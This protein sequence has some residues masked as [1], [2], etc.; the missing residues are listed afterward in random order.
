MFFWTLGLHSLS[1]QNLECVGITTIIPINEPAQLYAIDFVNG[2]GFLES[3]GNYETTDFI[4]EFKDAGGNVVPNFFP[5]LPYNRVYTYTVTHVPT[6]QMCDDILKVI[7]TLGIEPIICEADKHFA[8]SPGQSLEMLPTDFIELNAQKDKWYDLEIK[9]ANGNI[10]PANTLTY[11]AATRT[12]QATVTEISGNSC[13]ANFMVSGKKAGNS[14]A[15]CKSNLILALVNGTSKLYPFTVD[16]GSTDYVSLKLNRSEF[17]CDDVDRPIKVKLSAYDSQN[18]ISQCICSVRVEDKLPPVVQMYSNVSV[19]IN[20]FEP[21]IITPELV[22]NYYDNCGFEYVQVIPNQ[23]TCNSPNPLNVKLIVKDKSGATVSASTNVSFT[24]P[25]INT[26]LICKEEITIEVNPYAPTK[27]TPGL[28]LQGN[29]NCNADLQIVLSYNGSNF[30]KAEL[31]WE[32]ADKT[33]LGVI[34]DLTTGNTCQ[35]IILVSKVDV[36]TE[37]FTVCDT[38]CPDG[39]PGDCASGYSNDD[40]VD[41]PCSFDIFICSGDLA[42]K[43]TPE[44]LETLHGVPSKNV[45]PQIINFNCPTIYMVYTDIVIGLAPPPSQSKKVVRTWKVY[46]WLDGRIYDYI[47]VFKI[48]AEGLEICDTLPWNTPFGD[49]ASGHTDTDAVE[50]PA[51]ITVSNASVSL[52]ALKSNDSIHPNNVEPVLVENCSSGYVKTFS[53]VVTTID[54]NT[55]EIERT[56]EV[57]NW[58]VSQSKKYVQNITLISD[59]LNQICV[60][61]YLGQPISNV[62]LGQGLTT[63]SG[64]APITINPGEPDYDIIPTKSGN[65]KDGVDIMDLT[66]A[67]EHALGLINLNPYQI[68]AGDVSGNGGIS[69]LD[70][71]I[72]KKMVEGEITEW[73]NVPVWRFVDKNHTIINN[74][75]QPA[76]TFINTKN[77]IYS[78]EFIGFKM[79]DINHSYYDDGFVNSPVYTVLKAQDNTLNNGETYETTFSSDRNQ[80]LVAIK[81]EYLIKDNGITVSKVISDL[82]PGFDQAKNVVI[83]DEKV[84]ISWGADLNVYPQGAGLRNNDGLFKFEFVSNKNSV[85]SSILDLNP[86]VHNAI[87]QSG[88]TDPANVNLHWESKIVNGI[89]EKTLSNLKVFP[90]P[91][92]DN[93]QIV[94]LEADAKYE[95]SDAAGRTLLSGIVYTDGFVDLNTLN[96]GFYI[97]KISQNDRLHLTHKIIKLK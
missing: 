7:G 10:V 75:I 22:G 61:N 36:C 28:L 39:N 95:V 83:T 33:I 6:Q 93:I 80:N 30:P 45:R 16:N 19:E 52:N 26:E 24:I 63:P 89:I 77:L 92:Y 34:T 15:V 40:N 9:D 82:L 90:N 72:L 1:S 11:Q 65:A 50:W 14:T 18:I 51:D 79:G 64:C 44:E 3:L 62:D 29:Y 60:Q 97:L 96:N 55:K 47:H 53:D 56:W 78:N 87:K 23:I 25:N 31:N 20:S 5:P 84:E 32:D 85:L 73:P 38:R 12:F 8:I 49:C 43:I 2:N 37:T 58:I 57:R 86:E 76:K 68:A 94:G 54:A 35:T 81:L 4:V 91:F 48:I 88:T 59:N 71:V 74:L 13:V 42:D 46:N 66:M 21:F 69:T 67:Y 70:L 41:W 17:Y 27:I